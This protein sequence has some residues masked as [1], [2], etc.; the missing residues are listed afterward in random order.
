MEGKGEAGWIDRAIAVLAERQH[1]VVARRQLLELGISTGA[2][3]LRLAHRRLHRIHRGVY[4]LTSAALGPQAR[5]MAAVLAGGSGA[6]L[7]YWS[8][9]SLWQLRPGVGPRSH[10]TTPRHRLSHG[11][12]TFHQSR[13]T[14]DEITTEQNIPCTTP[15]R[16]L[17]DLAPLLPNPILGRMIE[18]APNRG[19][20]LAELLERYGRRAGAGRLRAVLAKA[21]PMTRSDFEALVLERIDRA[22]LP[23]PH[24]NTVVEGCEVDMCWPDR[25]VIAELDTYVTHGSRL[26]FERDRERD[27]KLAVAGWP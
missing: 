3:E 8:A 15:A 11:K 10:V 13:L 4:A 20:S 24:V 19:A 9:A 21:R 25:R 27:R 5:W 23:K 6:A 16:T 7:S 2:I 22:G 26:A 1:G 17:L 18:A 12:V 14:P